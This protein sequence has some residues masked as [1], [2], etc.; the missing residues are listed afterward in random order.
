MSSTTPTN[1]TDLSYTAS[2]TDVNLNEIIDK[3]VLPINEYAE[4]FR[5]NIDA[6]RAR[7]QRKKYAT[8]PLIQH[9][10]KVHGIVVDQSNQQVALDMQAYR[11]DT[12]NT[13]SNTTTNTEPMASNTLGAST[14]LDINP[15]IS[16]IKEQ[17]ESQLEMYRQQLKDKEVLV[18]S[19]DQLVE[20]LNQQLVQKTQEIETLNHEIANRNTQL[21]KYKSQ[22]ETM[23]E[24]LDSVKNLHKSQHKPWWKFWS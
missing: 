18:Q 2:D 8:V 20:S 15:V 3:E 12:S 11:S 17:Y 13:L 14:P 21:Q 16:I 22:E 19:K 7:V 24:I 1:D 4:R 10:R 9:G 5:V 23:N 6:V